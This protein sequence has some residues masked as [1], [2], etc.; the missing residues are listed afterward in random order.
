MLEWMGR[1]GEHVINFKIWD[2]KPILLF[3]KNDFFWNALLKFLIENK[4]YHVTA[5]LEYI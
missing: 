2:I 3:Q 4:A 5:N 1:G